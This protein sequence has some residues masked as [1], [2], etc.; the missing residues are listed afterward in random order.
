MKY[1]NYE[2]YDGSLEEAIQKLVD[3]GKTITCVTV[4]NYAETHHCSGQN[5]Y[6]P[7]R[8]LILYN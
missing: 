8:A 1:W 4:L 6:F 5:Q 2:D 7:I 3:R